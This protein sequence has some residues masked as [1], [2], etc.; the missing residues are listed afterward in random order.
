MEFVIEGKK[1]FWMEWLFTLFAFAWIA[2]ISFTRGENAFAELLIVGIAHVFAVKNTASRITLNDRGVSYKSL[3]ES[4]YY[5]W[6]EIADYGII[7]KKRLGRHGRYLVY[8]VYFSN[9]ENP[10][11]TAA[12]RLPYSGIR[13]RIRPQDV[14]PIACELRTF[15]R[16]YAKNAPYISE[17]C[18]SKRLLPFLSFKTILF[19]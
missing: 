8:T 4:K 5:L 14:E 18:T 10:A 19:E 1:R 2:F 12:K 11:E 16:A 15:G 13:M 3:F 7:H 6:N 9:M 17:Y